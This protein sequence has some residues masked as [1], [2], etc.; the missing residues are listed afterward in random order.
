MAAGPRR[1]YGA[2]MRRDLLRVLAAV[3]A[4][5]LAPAPTGCKPSGERAP[6]VAEE[7][8]LTTL[9]ARHEPL[10]AR[11]DREAVGPRLLVLASPT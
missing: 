9:D 8:A 11:F 2:G 4:L 1:C 10:R 7:A 6:A 5:A 3:A